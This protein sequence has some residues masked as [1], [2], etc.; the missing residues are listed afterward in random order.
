[1]F[2]NML[3]E[4]EGKNFL[5]L[6]N[7]AI[8]VDGEVDVREKNV[9]NVYRRELNLVDYKIQ[10]KEYKEIVTAFQASNKKVK[11]AVMIE[12][13]GVLDAD[14]NIDALE[15]GWINKL[16]I[17]WGFRDSEVKKMV[18]WTQDFNDLLTEGLE[19]INKR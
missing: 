8:N 3:N 7:I 1:M 18:R 9:M 19:Y 10:G 11:R 4:K 6:V 12:I 15:E 16:G 14:E 5:E 17:D 2:L 13:I